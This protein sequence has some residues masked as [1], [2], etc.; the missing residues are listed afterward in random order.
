MQR[1]NHD[2]VNSCSPIRKQ[3]FILNSIIVTISHSAAQEIRYIHINSAF[4]WAKSHPVVGAFRALVKSPRKLSVIKTNRFSLESEMKDCFNWVGHSLFSALK[5]EGQK[6]RERG[7]HQTHTACPEVFPL[8]GQFVVNKDG[9]SSSEAQETAVLTMVVPDGL[10]SAHQACTH[11]CTHTMAKR[12]T[13][14]GD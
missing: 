8:S 13:Q 6:D 2:V 9:V 14:R 11:V 4:A 1:K 12:Q 7:G 10:H 3:A 5:R